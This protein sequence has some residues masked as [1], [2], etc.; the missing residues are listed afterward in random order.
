MI[1]EKNSLSYNM[2]ALLI[3][4]ITEGYDNY[5]FGSTYNACLNGLGGNN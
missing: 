3:D 4:L 5:L 1:M 2:G